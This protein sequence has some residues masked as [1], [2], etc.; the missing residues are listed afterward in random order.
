MRH[1]V[2]HVQTVFD[3]RLLAIFLCLRASNIVVPTL[4]LR[5]M[6]KLLVLS[7]G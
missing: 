5:T 2:L 6:W 1:E 7:R 3:L 4:Y